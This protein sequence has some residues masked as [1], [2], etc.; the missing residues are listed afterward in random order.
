[1]GLL[2]SGGISSSGTVG[3]SSMKVKRTGTG[4]REC[5]AGVGGSEVG[6]R[7]CGVWWSERKGH[8]NM[9]PICC[10]NPPSRGHT[11]GAFGLYADRM[12]MVGGL[13][14]EVGKQGGR[15]RIWQWNR[16][17]TRSGRRCRGC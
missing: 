5:V 9:T 16:H 4:V 17:F 3:R 12:C 14:G 10:L 11:L 15:G 2:D 13:H 1:M 7:R 8:A 6:S